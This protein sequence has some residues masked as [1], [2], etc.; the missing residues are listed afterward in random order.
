LGVDKGEEVIVH[1]EWSVHPKYGRQFEMVRW[2]RPLPATEEQAIAF[3]SSGLIKG[4]GPKLAKA[5]VGHLGSSAVEIMMEKGESAIRHIRGIGEK[6]ARSIIESVKANFEVQKIIGELGQ[7]GITTNM[8]MKIYKEYGS[9][10]V[11]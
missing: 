4:C 3:L 2:E 1:G 11:S 5:I 8:S 7:F 10:A 6:N 9:N